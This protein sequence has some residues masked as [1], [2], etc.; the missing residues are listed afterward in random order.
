M[1]GSRNRPAAPIA[2]MRRSACVFERSRW[3]GVGST[4]RR[5]SEAK[6][7]GAPAYGS[8]YAPRTAP[9]ACST[10]AESTAIS[11]P[12]ESRR[13]SRRS[14]P[15]APRAEP[16]HEV[17]GVP[18]M[19]D[20]AIRTCSNEQLTL[21]DTQ[22]ARVRGP[23]NTRRPHSKRQA[24]QHERDPDPANRL[25][26]RSYSEG[27]QHRREYDREDRQAKGRAEATRGTAV[28]GT[29]HETARLRASSQHAFQ[30][31][32]GDQDQDRRERRQRRTP[33]FGEPPG[34]RTRNQEIKS[35]LLCR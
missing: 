2:S 16:H 32:E 26:Q 20:D 22:R 24:P 35:L 33:R 14:R 10:W 28:E 19:T 29:G 25:R 6:R 15:R 11:V 3:N 23:K 4:L 7:S 5:G 1:T 34:T 27:V 21:G 9:P 8:R 12:P 30:C 31:E 17:A 13:L 18:R